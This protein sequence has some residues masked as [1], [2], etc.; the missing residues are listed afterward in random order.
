VPVPDKAIRKLVIATGQAAQ[1]AGARARQQASRHQPF[2][3]GAG[4][5]AAGEWDAPPRCGCPGLP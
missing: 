2:R 3:V 1:A 4:R 5:A